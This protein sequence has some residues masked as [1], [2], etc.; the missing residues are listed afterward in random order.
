MERCRASRWSREHLEGVCRP[1]AD[2]GETPAA[3]NDLSTGCLSDLYVSETFLDGHTFR[4]GASG[5]NGN[6]YG[7]PRDKPPSTGKCDAIATLR[8]SCASEHEATC[9]NEHQDREQQ[10]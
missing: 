2:R 9:E 7:R 5:R 6:L 1:V 4:D 3:L 8:V 10:Q